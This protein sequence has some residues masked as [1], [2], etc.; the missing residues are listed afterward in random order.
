ME[1]LYRNGSHSGVL[2]S[3]PVK[4]LWSLWYILMIVFFPF[5]IKTIIY[6]DFVLSVSFSLFIL[7]ASV[8][9]YYLTKNKTPPFTVYLPM[10]LMCLSQS[11]GIYY[12]G[13]QAVFWAYPVIIIS[14]FVMPDRAAI[15]ISIL[16]T[17]LSGVFLYIQTEISL[18]IRFVFS[19][20]VVCVLIRI[21]IRFVLSL[22][23]ELVKLSITDPLTHAFNRRYMD[24]QLKANLSSRK[25]ATLLMID[26]DHFKQVNDIHGHDAGDEVLKR[27]VLCLQTH[28]RQDDLVFRMGGE[29]FVMLL[30]NTG[31][32]K[33]KVYANFLREQLAKIAIGDTDK[34]ITVSIGASELNTQ[35]SLDEWL[36][37][38]D[39]CLYQAKSQGR[40]QVII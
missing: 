1:K 14:Y 5:L 24:D 17:L 31:K 32:E 27:L 18:F 30:A 20:I 25:I 9:L 16:L 3:L 21:M 7:T 4:T 13:I 2:A 10:T 39:V 6:R 23:D 22:K 33:A 11:L 26:I 12:T 8:Y 37:Q 19:M 29:E 40:N 34:A 28:A 15:I 38:A 36:K 35:I